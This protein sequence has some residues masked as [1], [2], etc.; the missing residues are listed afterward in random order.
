MVL[1]LSFCFIPLAGQKQALQRVRDFSPILLFTDGSPACVALFALVT[2]QIV[3]PVLGDYFDIPGLVKDS[4]KCTEEEQR[5]SDLFNNVF[6][7]VVGILF[8]MTLT[9][10]AILLGLVE[11]QPVV[12]FPEYV[13][14]YSYHLGCLLVVMQTTGTTLVFFLLEETM[15][16]GGM[17]TYG[18]AARTFIVLLIVS[19]LFWKVGLLVQDTYRDSGT[20]S[21][22]ISGVFRL[23]LVTAITFSIILVL[24]WTR[25]M[26]KR[27]EIYI[28][29]RRRFETVSIAIFD[30]MLPFPI[31]LSLYVL[32]QLPKMGAIPQWMLYLKQG[33]LWLLYVALICFT[34][35]HGYRLFLNEKMSHTQIEHDFE[36]RKVE[37]RNRR[38]DPKAIHEE[39]GKAVKISY[40]WG[41]LLMV[42]LVL[43][44]ESFHALL[45]AEE[46][47]LLVHFLIIY[48]GLFSDLLHGPIK[49]QNT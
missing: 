47:L 34:I 10:A 39:I 12:A 40:V 36:L 46:M 49:K 23:M 26:Q 22:S 37:I 24:L 20:V 41:P 45:A 16:L 6:V 29:N 38:D 33:P 3:V 43:V 48:S 14:S 28:R 11:I 18:S 30:Y 17:L 32:L 5:L 15:R 25:Y 35:P 21:E 44:A 31:V 4:R 1:F 42:V 8:A 2:S 9:L 27:T 19:K 7:K 13:G